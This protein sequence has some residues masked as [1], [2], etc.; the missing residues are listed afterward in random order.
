MAASPHP[1]LPPPTRQ[2]FV[3]FP[4]RRPR[5]RHDLEDI[6]REFGRLKHTHL[7]NNGSPAFVWYYHLEDA[8][9]AVRRLDRREHMGYE[10]RVEHSRV[11]RLLAVGDVPP[12]G[13]LNVEAVVREAVA[14]HGAVEWTMY[15][16]HK[17]IVFVMMRSEAEA[18]RVVSE[19]QG[20]VRGGWRWEL[21][22]YKVRRARR[23]GF[24][25]PLPRVRNNEHRKT[26]SDHRCVVTHKTLVQRCQAPYR[27]RRPARFQLWRIARHQ[28]LQQ[29]RHR[30]RCFLPL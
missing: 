5:S 30:H 11:T 7:S 14:A 21:E 27:Q 12:R 22:F 16:A 15:D 18:A 3:R 8:R 23:V 17:C 6:F 9:E 20:R 4:V 13:V 26:Q 1:P 19:L 28:V 25:S 29:Q 2:L 24:F 10:L